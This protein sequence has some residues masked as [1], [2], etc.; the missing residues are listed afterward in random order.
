MEA[1]M[2]TQM[3]PSGPGLLLVG[4]IVASSQKVLIRTD[5]TGAVTSVRE[6]DGLASVVSWPDGSYVVV[7]VARPAEQHRDGGTVRRSGGGRGS[8]AAISAPAYPA[9][10]LQLAALA[11]GRFFAALGTD[12]F[13]FESPGTTVGIRGQFF[14]VRADGTVVQAGSDFLV[15]QNTVGPQAH[16]SVAAMPDGGAPPWSGRAT[17]PAIDPRCW[18]AS[19]CA[20]ST[21]LDYTHVA[22]SPTGKACFPVDGDDGDVAVVNLTPV[23]AQ[24]PGNGVL[25][26]PDVLPPGGGDGVERQLFLPGSFDPNVALAPVLEGVVC[27]LNSASRERAPGRRSPGFHRSEFVHTHLGTANSTGGPVRK[28]DTRTGVGGFKVGPSGLLRFVVVGSPGDVAV[29][30]L[31]PVEAEGWGNG[32]LVSSDVVSAPVASNGVFLA[33]FVRSECGVGADRCGW[34]GVFREQRAYERAFGRGSLGDDSCVRRRSACRVV[35]C[36][37]A[38]WWTRGWG[39]VCVCGGLVGLGRASRSVGSPGDVAVGEPGMPANVAGLGNG[40]LVSF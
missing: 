12:L 23:E 10:G 25:L 4:S 15:N 26:S 3:V 1:M 9:D 34:S 24:S 32:Q 19:A 40:Q 37:G 31:T 28:V 11:D 22:V 5:A 30:N 13:G 39:W 14:D 35:G 6:I 27:Y 29:V 2:A 20:S 16:P 33:G 36:A 7:D 21:R 8:G 38:G 17:T 18:V